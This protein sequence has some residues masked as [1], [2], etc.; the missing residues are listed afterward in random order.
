[1][2]RCL[3]TLRG[4]PNFRVCQLALA[5]ATCAFL[6]TGGA[7][8]SSN[9]STGSDPAARKDNRHAPISSHGAPTYASNADRTVSAAAPG[10]GADGSCNS[11][12]VSVGASGDP[13]D[14]SRDPMNPDR[15]KPITV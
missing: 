15:A 10:D 12:T 3:S 7:M 8:A 1:M 11:I 14:T 9:G 4:I 2:T 5:V 13:A 6:S